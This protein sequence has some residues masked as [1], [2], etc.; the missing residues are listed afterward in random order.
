VGGIQLIVKRAN[1]F[2]A[3][4]EAAYNGSRTI[5]YPASGGASNRDIVDISLA[6]YLEI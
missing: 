1:E 2:H 5:S 3:R 6:Q 4:W